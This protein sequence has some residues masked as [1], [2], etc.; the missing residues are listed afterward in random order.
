MNMPDRFKIVAYIDG[1]LTLEQSAEMELSLS[2]ESLQGLQREGALEARLAE[3]LKGPGCPVALWGQLKRQMTSEKHAAQFRIRRFPKKRWLWVPLAASLAV[4]AGLR[5]SSDDLSF[6]ERVSTVAALQA[7]A[8]LHNP[9][10]VMAENGFDLTIMTVPPG[11]HSIEVLGGYTAK[12]AHESVAVV[13]VNCCGKPIRVLVARRGSRAAKAL[14]DCETL[15]SVSWRGD[16]QLAVIAESPT[17][18]ALN[19]FKHV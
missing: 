9:M 10:D 6:L 15:Q 11:G 14:R 3:H 18:E 17:D 1:E 2:D 5:F 16:L 8:V 4:V 12:I 13:C 7:E 19:L